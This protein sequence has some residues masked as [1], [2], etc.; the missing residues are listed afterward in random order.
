MTSKKTAICT[1]YGNFQY[2]RMPFGL[3]GAAQTFQRFID[4]VTRNLTVPAQD[5]L[6]PPRKVNHFAYI[7]DI[8]VA[9]RNEKEHQED[10]AALFQ[11]LDDYGLKLNLDKCKFGVPQLSFL[12]HEIT[13]HGTKPMPAKVQANSIVHQATDGTRPAPISWTN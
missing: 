12:G 6:S 7:D 1:P 13:Q 11:R 9:S 3:C 10:L 8:L 5:P 2:K 4:K